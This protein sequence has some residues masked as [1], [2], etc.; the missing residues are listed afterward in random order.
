LEL[1]RL[2][3]GYWVLRV[4][5]GGLRV[6]LGAGFKHV[7][8]RWLPLRFLN[9][10]GRCGLAYLPKDLFGFHEVFLGCY[11]G[12]GEG[13][14]KAFMWDFKRLEVIGCCLCLFRGRRLG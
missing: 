5:N 6:I 11:G 14:V 9:Y 4:F 10:W 2:L 12:V 7:Y 8:G 1:G 13:G 3:S